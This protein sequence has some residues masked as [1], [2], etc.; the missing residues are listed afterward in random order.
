MNTPKTLNKQDGNIITYIL[1]AIFI[2]GLLTLAVTEGPKKSAVTMQLDKSIQIL[3]NGFT[4]I[5]S[6]ANQCALL[7]PTPI[8]IDNDGDTDTSDNPNPPYPIIYRSISGYTTSG[9]LNRVICPGTP[10]TP[11]TVPTVPDPKQYLFT[12]QSNNAFQMMGNTTLFTASYLTSTSEGIY[13]EIQS[14]DAANTLWPEVA[15]RVNAVLSACKAAVV[16]TGG[17]CTA[18]NP[19]L[20]YWIK[21]PATSTIGMPEAGCT[22]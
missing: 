22:L 1:I 15:T 20:Y 11:L 5:E 4:S 6:A 12:T 8:D 10:P 14:A 3:L 17:I 2:L 19:C 7:Y 21:R 16:T 18:T 9:A 13:L